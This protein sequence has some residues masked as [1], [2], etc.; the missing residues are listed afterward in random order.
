MGQNSVLTREK[1]QYCDMSNN[2]EPRSDISSRTDRFTKIK[3]GIISPLVSE[4]FSE[5]NVYHCGFFEDTF[6]SHRFFETQTFIQRNVICISAYPSTCC[7]FQV[8]WLQNSRRPLNGMRYRAPRMLAEQEISFD[9]LSLSF[10]LSL[11]P[12]QRLTNHRGL[13]VYK[14]AVYDVDF[15]TTATRP[16]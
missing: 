13:A 11:R 8:S 16:H 1:G 6:P 5:E 2:Q 14:S 4:T 12:T 9:S 3:L 15:T 10:A 7:N